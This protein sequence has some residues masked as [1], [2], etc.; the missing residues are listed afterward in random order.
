MTV[1]SVAQTIEC[2][3]HFGER[4]RS[5]EKTTVLLIYGEMG[6]GKTH[7]V[8]GIAIGLGITDTIT[9]PTFALVNSYRSAAGGSTDSISLHH[10]DLFRIHTLD[11]LYAIGFYDYISTGIL[12]IEWPQNIPELELE[13]ESYHTVTIEKTGESERKITIDSSRT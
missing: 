10:F 11:D 1:C 6:A 3:K 7:F 12:A 13:L 4:L 8:K 9:S 2:G 5:N